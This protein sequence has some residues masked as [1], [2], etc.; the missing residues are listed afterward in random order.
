MKCRADDALVSL[1][2]ADDLAKA[3][4]LIMAGQVTADT[5]RIDKPG[6]M[7]EDDAEVRVK[8]R[9]HPW[10]GR[11]G[12]KLD[13]ALGFFSIDVTGL[14][15]LDVGAST[16]GFT[17]VLLTRGAVHVYAVDVGTNQLAWKLRQDARVTV[18]EQTDARQLTRT[19]IPVAPQIVVC[20][21][22]FI[23]LDQVLPAALELA[24]PGAILVA[25][26]KP[27]FE[28]VHAM[29][30]EGGIVTDAA[31]HEAVTQA[32]IAWLESIGWCVQGTTPS[33]IT[34]ADGNR[35][36]LVAARRGDTND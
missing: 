29:V 3:R 7:I 32:A 14:T 35:E 16:G 30:G 27:Q 8:G 31:V 26:V 22:S 21:A 2:L 17:D 13:H 33:P 1:G 25:L 10:V 9:G 23:R 4:A 19:L 24:V 28:A 15:A 6:A 11:G 34:G 18:L 5:A 20:D 12:V 36:F